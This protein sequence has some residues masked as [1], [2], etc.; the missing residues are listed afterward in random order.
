[1]LNSYSGKEYT[2]IKVYPKAG[3]NIEFIGTR[4]PH[5]GKKEG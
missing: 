5:S 3:T 2:E 1:M 4:N